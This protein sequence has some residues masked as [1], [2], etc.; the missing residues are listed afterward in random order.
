MSYRLL[1]RRKACR[2]VLPKMNSQRPA[3]AAREHLKIP[4]GLGRFH[5]AK[6]ILLAR[7][8]QLDRVV[9][10]DLQEHTGIRAAFIGLAGGMEKPGSE[11]ETGRDATR[12]AD[13]V[14]N[15]LQLRFMSVVPLYVAEEGKIIAGLQAAEMSAQITQEIQVFSGRLLQG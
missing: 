3:I 5:R 11:P 6:R 7:D 9:T 15:C 14:P 4:S 1:K 10:R 8:G 2:D 12:I 13:R